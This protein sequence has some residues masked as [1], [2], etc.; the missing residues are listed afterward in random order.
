MSGAYLR[1]AAE[2]SAEA[3]GAGGGL[4][5]KAAKAPAIRR[6]THLAA[7]PCHSRGPNP[8]LIQ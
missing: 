4:T 5:E 7:S 8:L 1:T 3:A 2:T 6:A